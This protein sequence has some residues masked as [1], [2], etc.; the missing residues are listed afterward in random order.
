MG[1]G[2]DL[3]NLIRKLDDVTKDKATSKHAWEALQISIFS[4]HKMNM[5]QIPTHLRTVLNRYRKEAWYKRCFL[6]PTTLR[7]DD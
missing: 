3:Q 4:I 7:F 1:D 5:N 6:S 2:T